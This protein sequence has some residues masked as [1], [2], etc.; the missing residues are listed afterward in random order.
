[1][2]RPAQVRQNSHN[3]AMVPVEVPNCRLCGAS[4]SAPVSPTPVRAMWHCRKCDLIFVDDVALPPSEQE[5]ERY[6]KHQNHIDDE[7]YVATF[8]QIRQLVRDHARTKPQPHLLD[9]G[10]GPVPVLV[11]L[12]RRESF[13][14]KGYDPYFTPTLCDGEQFDVITCVETVEHFARP[15]RSFEQIDAHLKAN[16]VFIMQTQWHHGPETI[17]DWWY[18]RDITHVAFYSDATLPTIAEILHADEY[19]SPTAGISIFRRND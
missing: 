6:L 17:H 12:M 14:A 15:R 8:D 4:C 16:G 1:M 11:E 9:F 19:E 10:C 7:G 5:R 3:A 2:S 13:D 18:A